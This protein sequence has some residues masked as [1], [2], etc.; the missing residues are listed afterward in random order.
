LEKN[1]RLVPQFP[2]GFTDENRTS[3]SARLSEAWSVG[4]VTDGIVGDTIS[5]GSKKSGGIFEIFGAHFNLL[6]TE[7]T[8]GI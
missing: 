7:I 4:T 6:P 1:Y 2:I 8:N 5:D 3:R